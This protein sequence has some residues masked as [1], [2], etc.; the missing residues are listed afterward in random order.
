L[1]LDQN[2]GSVNPRST[3]GTISEVYDYLRLLMAKAGDVQCYR[4]QQPITQQT[5]VEICQR[6]LK[7]PEGSRLMLLSPRHR[8]IAAIGWTTG[9]LN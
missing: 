9:T 3:V 2:P 6:I 4:C 5:A 8:P 7:L 1:C